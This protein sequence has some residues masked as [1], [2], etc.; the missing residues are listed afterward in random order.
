MTHAVGT[1]MNVWGT[2]HTLDKKEVI[3]PER[4]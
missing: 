1:S 3:K 4:Q 2:K